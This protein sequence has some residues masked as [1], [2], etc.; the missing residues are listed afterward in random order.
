MNELQILLLIVVGFMMAV[1]FILSVMISNLVTKFP[2]LE[3]VF[4][5]TEEVDRDGNPIDENF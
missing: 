4:F 2:N 3:S 5:H 1:G